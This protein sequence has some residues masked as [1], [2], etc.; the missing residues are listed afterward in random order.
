MIV[1]FRYFRRLK[2]AWLRP[3]PLL[4]RWVT[5]VMLLAYLAAT[6]GYPEYRA[7]ASKESGEPFPCQ[8]SVCGCRT[9]EQC[10]KSCCCHTKESKIAWAL[11]RGIDPNRVAI[12]TPEESARYAQRKPATCCHP[13]K[14]G[15]CSSQTTSG[16]TESRSCCAKK[17]PP[18]GLSFV[19][20]IQAQKCRGSSMDWIQAGFVAL[21]PEPVTLAIMQRATSSTIADPP[22]YLSP[23]LEKLVPPG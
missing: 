10:R 21:P 18:G 19:L 4:R 5:A 20:G 14:K 23:T 7:A 11:E 22:G 2:K 12:L 13:A 17:A 6:I 16:S 8:H 1:R 15:C 9:A 3:A